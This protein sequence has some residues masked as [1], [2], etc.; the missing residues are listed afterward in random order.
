MT[1]DQFTGINAGY[2]L[3]LYERFR[4]DPSSIDPATRQ[5]FESW[6]PLEPAPT[7]PAGSAVNLRAVV[8]ATNLASCLRRFGHLGAKLDPLGTPPQGDPTLSPAFHGIT[9]EDLRALPAS[10]VGGVVAASSTNALEAI[11]KL[12]RVYC[13]STGFDISHVFVTEERDWLRHSAESG[14]F[15]PSMDPESSEALLRSEEHTSELQSQ[16]N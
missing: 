8:G 6:Q 5:L 4:A 14:R 15:L 12:R 11:E 10:L 16:S 1:L 2:V 7:Q 3:E 13:S 9:N